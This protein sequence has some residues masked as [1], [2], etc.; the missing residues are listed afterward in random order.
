LGALIPAVGGTCED[1]TYVVRLEE[2]RTQCV[3]RGAATDAPNDAG[4]CCAVTPDL[5]LCTE[6]WHPVALTNTGI[7]ATT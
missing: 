2:D 3:V 1:Q 5:M 4:D 6:G 7:L